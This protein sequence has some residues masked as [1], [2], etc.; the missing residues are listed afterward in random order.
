MKETTLYRF[1]DVDGKLLYI[2]ITDNYPLRLI[3]HGKDKPWW[4]EV[5]KFAA[6]R[7]PT[8]Q[9]AEEAEKLA[10][11]SELPKYNKA[12]APAKHAEM[13]GPETPELDPETGEVVPKW[14]GYLYWNEAVARVGA[15]EWTLRM[16]IMQGHF[17]QPSK[18]LRYKA[19]FESVWTTASVEEWERENLVPP[20]VTEPYPEPWSIRRKRPL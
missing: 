11:R 2:G 16:A 8:R 1:F 19:K 7:L 12:H 14:P 6:E 13:G 4:D 10:I 3:H 9:D 15:D 20:W 17:P 18:S 5:K